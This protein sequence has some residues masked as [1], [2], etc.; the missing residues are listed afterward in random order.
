MIT[1]KYLD[2]CIRSVLW[3][4]YPALGILLVEDGSSG[5]CPALCDSYAA[6]YDHVTTI[7]QENRGGDCPVTQAWMP[8]VASVFFS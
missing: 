3:Q 1:E 4:D 5:G 2:D 6:A 8:P 7:H